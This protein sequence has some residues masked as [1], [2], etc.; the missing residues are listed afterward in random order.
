VLINAIL[1]SGKLTGKGK[2]MLLAYVKLSTPKKIFASKSF[3]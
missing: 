1:L 2:T 3:E